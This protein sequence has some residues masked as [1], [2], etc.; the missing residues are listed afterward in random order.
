MRPARRM[1]DSDHFRSWEITGAAHSS[2]FSEQYRTPIVERDFG[3]DV[4]PATCTKPPFS[5]VRGPDVINVQYD[6]LVRWIKENVAPP[7][8]PKIEFTSAE[9]PT[10]VRDELGFA[11]GGI[12][13][14]DVA[15]PV[16]LHTGVNSGSTFCGLYGSYEPFDA[17]TLN[18]LYPDATAY[19]AAVKQSAEQNVAAG[20][21]L[22]GAAEALVRAA[23]SANVPPR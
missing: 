18:K 9:P 16:A 20:Y 8:A 5:R 4:W 21:I 7:S 2:Y 23:E 14:P 13:L 15:A 19:R 11:R 22:P 12:R 10:M 17:A 3:T 6:L 1:A